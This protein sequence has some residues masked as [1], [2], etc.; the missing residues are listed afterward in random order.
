MEQSEGFSVPLGEKGFLWKL[1]DTK[2]KYW[3]ERYREKWKHPPGPPKSKLF[4]RLI[5]NKG[6]LNRYL[7]EANNFHLHSCMFGLEK[8]RIPVLDL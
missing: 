3:E 5:E 1:P 4:K 2:S 8:N 7:T 6:V